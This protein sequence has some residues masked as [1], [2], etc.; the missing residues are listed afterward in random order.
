MIERQDPAHG[1]SQRNARLISCDLPLRPGADL[2]LGSHLISPRTFYT[3]HGI[4]VGNGRVIHYSGL[5]YGLRRGPVEEVSLEHFAHGHEVGVRHD[6]RIFDRREVVERARSRL[7]E[8][9]YRILTNNCAHL[10]AWALRNEGGSWRI[11]RFHVVA[12]SLYRAL[13]SQY[14]RIARHHRAIPADFR[15]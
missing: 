9:R 14:E 8:R 2:P 1:T 11:E 10:C 6:R 13:R 15:N 4:Y 12:L 5:A 3:H 7:G